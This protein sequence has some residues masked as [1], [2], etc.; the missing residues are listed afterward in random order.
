MNSVKKDLIGFVCFLL[1]GIGFLIYAIF[2]QSLTEYNSSLLH[3]LSIG[4]G[5]MGLL[6]SL[7]CLKFMRDP[8]KCAE[9]EICKNEERTVFIR[10]KTNSTVYS[11]FI[12]IESIAVVICGLLDYKNISVAISFLLIGKL[13]LWFMLG[14]YYGKKY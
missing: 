4:F 10:E 1:F 11:T 7:I 2:G 14:T 12:Y 5:V 3:S 6:G 9:I 8:K 13:V